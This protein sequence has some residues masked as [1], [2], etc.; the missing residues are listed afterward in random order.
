MNAGLEKIK[1]E[2]KF[3]RLISHYVDSYSRSQGIRQD[4]LT[5]G[6]IVINPEFLNHL[7]NDVKSQVEFLVK[8]ANS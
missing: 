6:H 5:C 2:E 3:N 4:D 7:P 1:F 8:S